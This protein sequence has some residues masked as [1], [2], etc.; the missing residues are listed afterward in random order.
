MPRA[1]GAA[2]AF[3]LVE[4]LVV[5]SVV[6][7]L[8]CLLL[9]ALGRARQAG[10]STS[11]AANL[12]SIGGAVTLYH[13]QFA[14]RFPLSSHTTGSLTDDAAWLQSLVPF[15]VIPQDRFCRADAA[16][17]QKL[18]S[19]ATNDHFEPLMPGID[20]D[21][22]TGKSLPGGR[23]FAYT[24]ISLMPRPSTT[25][26]VVEPDAKGTVD[27][28]H[29]IGWTKPEQVRATIAI[30]RH[31]GAGNFLF[32]DCHAGPVTW[33]TVQATFSKTRNFLNPEA[34]P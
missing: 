5:V 3:S 28:V 31:L 6:S 2:R 23:T 16:R 10:W 30:T 4:L 15:G 9:P 34:A 33:S 20:Y 24:R 7:V 1:R 26:Y 27:H 32:A 13:N 22:F 21:P 29:S 14:D 11:C 8:I 12:H 17:E 18:T 19:Y 25:A